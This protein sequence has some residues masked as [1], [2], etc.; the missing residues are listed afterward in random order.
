MRKSWISL[1]AVCLSAAWA[2]PAGAITLYAVFGGSDSET[3]TG[4]TLGNSLTFEYR[5]HHVAYT[6]GPW[7]G[8]NATVVNPL[9]G[10][11]P[12]GQ[13]N[14]YR[15]ADTGWLP[16]FINTSSGFGTVHDL[17]FTANAFSAASNSGAV[18]IRSIRIDGRDIASVPE[19]GTMALLG[20]GLLGL[21]LARRKIV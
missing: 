6:S 8:I 21:G 19:P 12:A 1:L 16:A 18:D 4:L 17:A 13:F 15:N 9:L 7:L 3:V 20:L 10:S 11:F 14:D 2:A 5:F